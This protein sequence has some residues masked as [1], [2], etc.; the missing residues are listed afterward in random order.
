MSDSAELW[1]VG[2]LAAYLNKPVS[3]VY[4]NYRER[5][6]FYKV[7]RAL[8]FDPGEIRAALREQQHPN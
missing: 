2:Q 8:R 4:D 5:F 1:T 6:P 7:G 3:W